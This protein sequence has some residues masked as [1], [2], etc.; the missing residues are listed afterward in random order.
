MTFDPQL[1]HAKA[2]IVTGAAGDIGLSIAVHLHRA[3][4]SVAL[5]DLDPD[6]LR[7]RLPDALAGS[8]RVMLAGCDVSDA[9]RTA[10]CVEQVAARFGS[11][12]F[13]VN[14]AAA[15]T[16]TA[17]LADLPIDEWDRALAVNLRG[18]FLMTRW[19]I[20]HLRAAGGGTV[21]NVASQLGHVTA[22]GRAAYSASKAGLLSLTRSIAVDHAGDGIRALSLS[23]G[24][25]ATGR[26]VRRY[27]STEL[28]TG[29]LAPKYPVGRLGTADEVARMAV[30]LIG[31]DVAFATGTD[32]L[33]DGGYTA[34]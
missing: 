11:I 34:V 8:P 28:A 21:L 9:E 25:I 4:A 7:E 13:L 18:A 30:F 27:G 3:G 32:V 23:P 22:R 24:A 20:P 10:A 16:P 1:L 19:S 15:V 26:L 6:T 33:V 2:G 14:N 17:D 12:D 31:G 5:V 29:A